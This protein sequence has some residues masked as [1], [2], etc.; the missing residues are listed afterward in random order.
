MI[1]WRKKFPVVLWSNGDCVEKVLEMTTNEKQTVTLKNK[2]SKR[3]K[4]T[5]D[6]KDA[7][8][9][10]VVNEL[11]VNYSCLLL[12]ISIS[13]KSREYFRRRACRKYQTNLLSS[14][15]YNASFSIRV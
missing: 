2:K 1:N 13:F 15:I 9:G 6:Q 7:K 5:T 3:S 12:T 8:L 14:F 4:K 10:R 11:I